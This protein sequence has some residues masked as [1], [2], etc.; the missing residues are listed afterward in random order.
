MCINNLGHMTKMAA[1]P[2]YGKNPSKIIFSETNRLISRKLG[3]RHR[4]LKYSNVYI[5]H[6]RVMTL[7]K[8]MARSTWV[9][10]ASELGKLLKCHLKE[11]AN[12]KLA[13]GQ[14]IEDSEKRKWPKGLSAPAL[15]LNTIIFKHVYCYMQLISGERLQDHWS[16]GS[17]F[18]FRYRNGVRGHMKSVIQ[19]LLRQY[20]R[21]E[22]QFQHGQ[23]YQFNKFVAE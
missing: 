20:L 7:T 3:V 16:S 12:R 9:A 22:T 11:K 19:D 10:C 15:E 14:N 18:C 4:W 13:N 8:F 5:N 1:M 23:F 6:D 17:F 2:I 21:V